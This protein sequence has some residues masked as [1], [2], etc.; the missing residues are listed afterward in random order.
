MEPRIYDTEK[1]LKNLPLDERSF[2]ARSEELAE[3]GEKEDP[4]DTPF[5][6]IS[7][8]EVSGSAEVIV[9]DAKFNISYSDVDPEF[10]KDI[11]TQATLDSLAGKIRQLDALSITSVSDPTVAVEISQLLPTDCKILF[12]PADKLVKASAIYEK[13]MVLYIADPFTQKAFPVILHEIG[14]LIDHSNLRAHGLDKFVTDHEYAPQAEK[15]RRERFASAYALDKLRP[16]FRAHLLDKEQII[17]FLKKYALETYNCSLD[18]E[19]SFDLDRKSE[20]TRQARDY[21]E[22]MSYL[23]EQQL[24]D[25]FREWQQTDEYKNWKQL[26]ENID[27]EDYEAFN[28]W[29]EITKI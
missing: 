15:L 21:N 29:R 19:I 11:F 1:Y 16:L 8:E 18:H 7:Y 10:Y 5:Q 20:G 12:Y 17:N 4:L 24:H 9:G 27:L 3:V 23:G 26:P 22:E 28:Y 25:D 6:K 13:N 14:H 2:G